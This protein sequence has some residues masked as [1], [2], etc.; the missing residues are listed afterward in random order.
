M[1][2][3]TVFTGR[4]PFRKLGRPLIAHLLEDHHKN[5]IVGGVISNLESIFYNDPMEGCEKLADVLP[6]GYRLAISHNPFLPFAVK[7][8]MKNELKAAAVRLFP[9]YHHYNPKD[10]HVVEFCRAAAEYGLIIYIIARMDDLRFDYLYRQMKPEFED[11]IKLAQAV[12]KGKFIISGYNGTEIMQMAKEISACPNVYVDCAYMCVPCFAY[13]NVVPLL[14]RGRL[15]FATHY[16]LQL[17]ESNTITIHLSD[18]SQE[19]KECIMYKNA[20]KLFGLF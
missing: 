9:V 5:G 18:I 19:D 14:P 11:V 16:P 12:P 8:V 20:Y 3:A 15:L 2:D 10:E 4:W 17:I 13:R 1:F 7:D 6:A